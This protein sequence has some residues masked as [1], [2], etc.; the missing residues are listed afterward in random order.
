M[1]EIKCLIF[2]ID[3]TLVARGKAGME[4]STKVALA[5]AKSKGLKTIIATGRSYYFIQQEILDF[6]FDYYVT[7]NGSCLLDESGNILTAHEMKISS[8]KQC[9]DSAKKYHVG[10]AFKYRDHIRTAA[11]HDY[12]IDNYRN[13]DGLDRRVIDYTANF[14]HHFD[15]LPLGCFVVGEQEDIKKVASENP[16]LQFKRAVG[17][18]YDVYDHTLGKTATIEEALKRMNLGWDQ[19]MAFGDAGNDS[20]MLKKAKIGVAMGQGNDEAKQAA[21]YITTAVTEDG[22]MNALKHFDLI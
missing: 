11:Y 19:A 12:F 14:D 7:I 22:I 10:I 18:G 13:S 5:A 6:K 8:M 2:D 20:V 1:N 4:E 16:D 3:G 15:E 9:I 17:I 21:D